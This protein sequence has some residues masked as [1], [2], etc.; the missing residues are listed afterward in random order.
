MADD[1][2]FGKKEVAF[3]RE[4]VKNRVPFMIVGLS[5]AALQGVSISTQDV[6][7][8]FRDLH[9][10]GLKKALRKAGGAYVP[11]IMMNPPMIAGGGLD[12]FDLVLNVSGLGNFDDEIK[13]TIAV[14]LGRLKVRILSLERIIKSKRAAGRKKD[15]VVLPLLEDALK[16]SRFEFKK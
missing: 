7:L 12:K 10:P 4:L 15:K 3:L 11:P 16:T 2:I 14:P 8:W 9:H 13:N 1:L 6:D 5:A